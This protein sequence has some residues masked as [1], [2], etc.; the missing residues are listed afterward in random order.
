[1]MLNMSTTT[2]YKAFVESASWDS[3]MAQEFYQQQHLQ[4]QFVPPPKESI[5]S[6]QFMVS[7]FESEEAEEDDDKEITM[8]DPY[9]PNQEKANQGNKCTEVAVYVPKKVDF[10]STLAPYNNVGS[11]LEIET[12]L[13][14]L[15]K[16]MNLAYRWVSFWFGFKI[17]FLIFN[18]F[19]FWIEK[20]DNLIF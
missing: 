9:D 6:G 13:S 11:H 12:S 1:M 5:H 4:G 10:S 8:P 2:N 20:N 17:F 16:C 15:F 7:T 19:D 14:K 3:S 18:N